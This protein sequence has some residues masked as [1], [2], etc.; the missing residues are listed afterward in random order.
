MAT[1]DAHTQHRDN[2]TFLC[3]ETTFFLLRTVHF[4]CGKEL[5]GFE[6]NFSFL[7]FPYF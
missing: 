6:K 4:L 5:C 1:H 2:S 3:P 7:R